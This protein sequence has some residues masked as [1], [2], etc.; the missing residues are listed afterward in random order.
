M[1]VFSRKM[2]SSEWQSLSY[3]PEM[4]LWLI[5]IAYSDRGS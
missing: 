5:L 2:M 1:E 4:I 3:E